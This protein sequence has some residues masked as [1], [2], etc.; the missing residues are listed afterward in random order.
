MQQSGKWLGAFGVTGIIIER[1]WRHSDPLFWVSA[2]LIG[3]AVVLEFSSE[4]F[5]DED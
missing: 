3:L 4:P 5:A 2:G 1:G